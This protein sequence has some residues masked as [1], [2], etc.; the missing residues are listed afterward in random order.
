MF[1]GEFEGMSLYRRSIMIPKRIQARR[2]MSLKKSFY[3]MKQPHKDWF[4]RFTLALKRCG[5]KK[6]NFDHTISHKQKG[7]LISCLIIYVDDM[8]ITW[9]NV[10][11]IG[12]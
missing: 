2:H 1:I 6:R 7:E 11:I 3:G 8:I 10:V 5:F 12:K 9:S 4:V